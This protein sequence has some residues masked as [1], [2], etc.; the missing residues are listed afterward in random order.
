MNY[1]KR[2]NTEY[3]PGLIANKIAAELRD[4]KVKKLYYTKRFSK[5]KGKTKK[6][7]ESLG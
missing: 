6:K 2:A 1:P 7:D 5:Q 4:E 3:I